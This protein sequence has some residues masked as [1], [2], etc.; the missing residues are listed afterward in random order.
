MGLDSV[1]LVMAWEREFG[2]DIPDEAVEHMLTPAVVID[3]ISQELGAVSDDPPQPCVS[4]LEFHQIRRELMAKGM[5]KS[6]IKPGTSLR[7][8][9]PFRHTVQDEVWK[10]VGVRAEALCK[11]P[12]PKWTRNEVRTVARHIIRHQIGVTRFSDSDEFIRDLGL[13]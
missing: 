6:E 8:M 12:Q 11:R 2:I 1:E 13:D 3:W 10:R 7:G 9:W 4:L 5:P